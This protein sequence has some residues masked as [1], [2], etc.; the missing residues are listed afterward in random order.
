MYFKMYH[1]EEE[2]KGEWK[3]LSKR[4]FIICALHQLQ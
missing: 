3:G 1:K 2:V 4:S